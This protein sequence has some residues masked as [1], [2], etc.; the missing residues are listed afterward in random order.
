ME[1]YQCQVYRVPGS[2][3]NSTGVS[4]LC[5]RSSKITG[6][7]A[8]RK[9]RNIKLTGGSYTHQ[10]TSESRPSNAPVAALISSRSRERALHSETINTNNMTTG[11]RSKGVGEHGVSN[12]RGGEGEHEGRP[13]FWV[14]ASTPGR[15]GRKKSGRMRSS[16]VQRLKRRELAENVRRQMRE[17]VATEPPEPRG[18]EGERRKSIGRQETERAPHGRCE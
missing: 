18:S 7:R 13:E 17:R 4:F 16:D 5:M 2:G 6:A 3:C 15:G 1:R 8:K 12:E 10:T 11:R 9:V 14:Q